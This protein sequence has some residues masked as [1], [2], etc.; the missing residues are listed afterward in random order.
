MTSGHTV[1]TDQC[2]GGERNKCRPANGGSW[3]KDRFDILDYPEKETEVD[4]IVQGLTISSH[5]G[6]V[7]LFFRIGPTMGSMAVGRDQWKL[8]KLKSL[9][10]KNQIGSHRC[11]WQ[12]KF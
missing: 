3:K 1:V 7:G 12:P 6:L 2:T 5:V 4:N 10:E 9:L 8:Q 11:Y